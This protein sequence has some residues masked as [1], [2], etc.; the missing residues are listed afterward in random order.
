M[1]EL[2]EDRKDRRVNPAVLCT[3][4]PLPVIK[5]LLSPVY[6]VSIYQA[7]VKVP[8][9]G[10]GERMDGNEERTKEA[11][12]RSLQPWESEMERKEQT[13]QATGQ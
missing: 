7:E 4:T 10:R 8:L 13:S 6:S 5:S 1:L 3:L 11:E 9:E 2:N 12:C